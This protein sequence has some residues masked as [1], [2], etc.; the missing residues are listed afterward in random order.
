MEPL[1]ISPKAR[2][3]WHFFAWIGSCS[4]GAGRKSLFEVGQV[5]FK[6]Q[7]L[8]FRVEGSGFRVWGSGF[9][10]QGLGL[11]G[12]SL[13]RQIRASRCHIDPDPEFHISDIL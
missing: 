8:G 2:A 13:L 11:G 3:T 4:L 10:V 12:P 9:G 6:V 7:D 5:K 1:E